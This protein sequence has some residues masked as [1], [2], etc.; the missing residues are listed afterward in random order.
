MKNLTRVTTFT[1]ATTLSMALLGACSGTPDAT[2]TAETEAVAS[3][4]RLL[5]ES[6]AELSAAKDDPRVPELKRSLEQRLASI[7]APVETSEEEG[8]S[9]ASQS[10]FA[11][12]GCSTEWWHDVLLGLA[13]QTS[14]STFNGACN[15][16][17]QCYASGFATY[18]LS[19]GSC[20]SAFR[21]KATDKCGSDYPLW[22]RVA[23]PS[24][25]LLYLRCIATAD[26]MYVAVDQ[27]GASHYSGV[28]CIGGQVW[29]PSSE[30]GPG[31]STYEPFDSSRTRICSG[32]SG[33]RADGSI[34]ANWDGCRGSGCAACSDA[35]TAYPRYFANHPLC[36]RN[37]TCA[38]QFFQCGSACP[39]PTAA[40]R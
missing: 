22:A 29:P 7:S 4:Q 14:P 23:F 18:G 26:T 34:G 36:S 28:A 9:S 19:R 11:G 16:H 40:D 21:S 31:C 12:N 37:T 25:N 15:W 10:L 6:L 13:F 8:F 3:E 1:F 2:P 33:M 39:A 32:A 30:S 35:L 20:D 24:T 27:K 5:Q 17:D 38:G